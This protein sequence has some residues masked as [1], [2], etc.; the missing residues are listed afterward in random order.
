[1]TTWAADRGCAKDRAVTRLDQ[2][3]A[4][5]ETGCV[6]SFRSFLVS[7]LPLG[8]FSDCGRLVGVLAFA[9]PDFTRFAALM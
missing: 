1:M 6:T 5:Q 4:V 7:V 2:L 9:P 8:A 3:D